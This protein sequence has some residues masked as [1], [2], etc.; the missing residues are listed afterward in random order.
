MLDSVVDYKSTV[1]RKAVTKLSPMFIRVIEPDQPNQGR[2]TSQNQNHA[3]EEHSF[4]DG[5]VSPPD[6]LI[7][8]QHTKSRNDANGNN[9]R[10]SGN[11]YNRA[12][13]NHKQGEQ[14]ECL[15]HL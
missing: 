13:Q 12:N 7:E 15:S 14:P 4:A 2:Y 8:L 1:R 3:D 5:M 6:E 10:R 9:R 11:I